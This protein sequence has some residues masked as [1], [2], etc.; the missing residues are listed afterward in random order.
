MKCTFLKAL[1]LLS[2]ATG[3]CA[4]GSG[5]N[6]STSSHGTLGLF[7]A[8]QTGE[9]SSPWGDG[10]VS[11]RPAMAVKFTAASYPVTITSVTI[12]AVNNTGSEQVFNV[13]GFSDLSTETEIFPSVQNN[14]LPDNGTSPQLK[15]ISIPATT[16]SS[17]SFYIAVEWMT[18]PLTSV[19][20]ANAFF[21][22]TDSHLDFPSAS[23]FRF[24][25]TTWSTVESVSATAGDLGI[26]VN[27]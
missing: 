25:G 6:S 1:L 5:E 19:S 2:L 8:G 23:Y 27:Y 10:S 12:Y 11:Q 22:R 20:G 16:I 9:N 4:C 26:V 24:S 14:I 3:L 17:G 7:T 21:L 18:K 15:T 13:H